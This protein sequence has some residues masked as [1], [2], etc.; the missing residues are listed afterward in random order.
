MGRPGAHLVGDFHAVSRREKLGG[1]TGSHPGR[2]API[3]PLLLIQRLVLDEE[4][5]A[6]RV[7]TLSSIFT[8]Y[9]GVKNSAVELEV[10][11]GGMHRSAHCSS[12]SAWCWMRSN[13]PAGCAPCRRFSRSIPA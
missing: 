7:R 1:G 5:W 13:G 8:Q 12:S 6:G 4:Q 3:C 9:P 10:T 11:Q 2:H